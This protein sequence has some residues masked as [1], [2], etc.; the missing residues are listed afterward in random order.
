[1]TKWAHVHWVL[2]RPSLQSEP[3][4]QLLSVKARPG[5][6]PYALFLCLCLNDHIKQV[7]RRQRLLEIQ[8]S[9]AVNHKTSV[10]ESVAAGGTEEVVAAEEVGNF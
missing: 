4:P 3:A 5:L 10:F 7:Q 9:L 2:T 8:H 1:M 6:W